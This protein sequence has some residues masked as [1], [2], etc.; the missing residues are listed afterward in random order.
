MLAGS[1]S[2]LDRAGQRGQEA[3]PRT[4]QGVAG[5]RPYPHPPCQRGQALARQTGLEPA[6]ARGGVARQAPLALPGQVARPEP[7]GP[8][9]AV[10]QE[11]QQGLP[12]ARE[13]IAEEERVA[14]AGEVAARPGRVVSEE[15]RGLVQQVVAQAGEVVA[16]AREVIAKAE[17][18]PEAGQAVAEVGEIVSRAGQGQEEQV[19]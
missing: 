4:Q 6:G 14:Q 17:R 15:G 8:R 2:G 1:E 12:L 5:S 3:L 19:A 10:A 9:Q 18:D 7:S 11:E 13:V 16:Q